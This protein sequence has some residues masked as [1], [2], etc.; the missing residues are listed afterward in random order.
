MLFKLLWVCVVWFGFF[1]GLWLLGIAAFGLHASGF[2]FL[3]L[4]GLGLGVRLFVCV[5]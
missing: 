2:W 3:R 5:L 4:F 1:V